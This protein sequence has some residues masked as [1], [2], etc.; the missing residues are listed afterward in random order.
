M[1]NLSSS[2][3]GVP[4]WLKYLRM[5][6]ALSNNIWFFG[7]W[8]T[9]SVTKEVGFNFNVNEIIYIKFKRPYVV[10]ATV[11]DSTDSNPHKKSEIMFLIL[12]I[13]EM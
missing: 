5:H 9:A 10:V 3:V 8:N 7:N 4:M 2:N 1:P 12:C 11:L 13:L 6:T